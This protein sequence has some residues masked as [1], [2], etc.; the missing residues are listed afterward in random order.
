MDFNSYNYFPVLK[1]KDAELRAVSNLDS[2][3]MDRILPIYELTK[4]RI[5]KKDPIGNISKRLED[6]GRIQAT[7]PFILDVTT[8]PK[9]KNSQT[10]AMLVPNGGYHNW[11]A[12]LTS[13]HE[14]NIT[15]I[16]HINFELDANLNETSKFVSICSS[17][18]EAFAVR[19]P[20][21]LDIEIYE[22]ILNAIT[23]NL[24]GA[25]LDVILDAGCIRDT[26]KRDGIKQITDEFHQCFNAIL[27][28]S[29]DTTWVRNIICIAGSFPL[30]VSKEGGDESG[31]FEI[32]EHTLWSLLKDKYPTVKFGDYG[33]INAQQVEIKGGTFVPRIDFCTD[34]TF[35]YHRYRRDKG[36]YS[37]CAQMVE[38]DRNYLD[39]GTWGDDEITI[40]ALGKPSGISP[41]FWISTR[42]NRY[43]SHR[44]ALYSSN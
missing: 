18:Y 38:A 9:Q 23:P 30:I 13:H 31:D 33:S 37:K 28:L 43:M 3:T 29:G 6:I 14:M 35:F 1:T 10:E 5:T 17:N 12:I 40:A 21:D 19:L 36:S 8:D 44:A 7:R 22:E 2:D 26:V 11:R 32:Y 27:K 39:F 41:S 15:P 20:P 34:D 25:K 4:S 42:A 24:N 16:I